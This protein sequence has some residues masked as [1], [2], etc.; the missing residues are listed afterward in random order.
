MGRSLPE[1]LARYNPEAEFAGLDLPKDKTGE[2]YLPLAIDPDQPGKRV[3]VHVLDEYR[4]PI[5]TQLV[6]IS[7]E[8]FVALRRKAHFS[9]GPFFRVR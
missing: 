8:G 6:S 2:P 4:D 1:I 9:T 3:M 7:E 5:N